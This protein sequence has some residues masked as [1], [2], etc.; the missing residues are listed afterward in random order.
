[1]MFESEYDGGDDY[2]DDDDYDYNADS[3]DYCYHDAWGEGYLAGRR[4]ML[5]HVALAKAFRSRF[6][7]ALIERTKYRARRLVKRLL[8]RPPSPDDDDLIPF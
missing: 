5:P 6:G 3:T 8:R 4:S 1:V 2:P 7:Y